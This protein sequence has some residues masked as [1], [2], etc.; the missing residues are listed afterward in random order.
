LIGEIGGIGVGVVGLNKNYIMFGQNIVM[1]ETLTKLLKE[2]RGDNWYYSWDIQQE[3]PLIEKISE[4]KLYRTYKYE[5]DSCGFSLLCPHPSV[6]LSKQ[7]ED[8]MNELGI[9]KSYLHA[10]SYIR[11]FVFPM[12]S[13]RVREDGKSTI[14]IF[15]IL[16]ELVGTEREP[17]ETETICRCCMEKH[18]EKELDTSEEPIISVK[19]TAFMKACEPKFSGMKYEFEPTNECYDY[20][21]E[22]MEKE[23]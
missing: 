22:C 2:I 23:N 21:I 1:Y 10:C 7:F 12:V 9:Q 3:L 14:M 17:N 15:N 18:M 6:K 8:N 19:T 20:M 16:K 13:Y 4:L 5:C 11:S